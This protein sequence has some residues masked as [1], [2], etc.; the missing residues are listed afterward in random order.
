MI[1]KKILIASVPADG[2]F[3]PL[4]GIAVHLKKL[5]YEVR[6]YTQDYYRLKIEKLGIKHC[7]FVVPPQLNQE[8]FHHAFPERE[9]LKSQIDRFRFDMKQFFILRCP[10]IL[11]DLENIHQEYPFELVIADVL[12]LALP[13][14]RQRLRVKTV[15][16]GIIPVNE[17]SADLPPAGLGLTPIDTPLGRVRNAFM[18]L[19]SNEVILKG[20]EK[21]YRTI[22][23]E[24]GVVAPRGN[25]FDIMYRTADQVW[26]SGTPGFEYRRRDWNP[27]IQFVGPLLPHNSLAQSTFTV[28]EPWKYERIVLVTQGTAEQ[29]CSKIIAPA[30]EAFRNTNVL[31]IATTGG[32]GTAQLKAQYPDPNFI[33]QDY[34]PF[35]AVMPYCDAYITNGGYGGVLLGIEHK[36]PMLVAGVHEGKN[37]ICARVGFFKLGINLKTERPTAEAIR[38]GIAE[39]TTQPEYKRNVVALAAEF[40]TYNPTDIIEK[41]LAGLFNGKVKLVRAANQGKA[42]GLNAVFAN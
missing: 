15:V 42:D 34:I 16:A 29:D 10:E 37:E 11:T 32:N 40:A 4:T 20:C 17:T 6:W 3:N 33:I 21:T 26:Q 31:V 22:L 2:H 14:V 9:K 18:R 12:F 39:I 28:D 25:I 30:L 24:K 13:L 5:G 7:P 41:N 8:N 23:K 1:N 36:L 38:A 35:R 19:I 27:R